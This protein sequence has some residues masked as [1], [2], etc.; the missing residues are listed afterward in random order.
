MTAIRGLSG[1]LAGL[2]LWTAGAPGLAAQAGDRHAL[3]TVLA[4]DQSP[5]SGLGPADFVVREDGAAR[6]VLSVTAAAPGTIVL[7]VDST[8]AARDVM[9][10]VRDGL[11]RFVDQVTAGPSRPAIRLATFADRPDTLADFGAGLPLLDKGIGLVVPRS[12]SGSRF[13]DALVETCRDLRATQRTGAA[14]VAFLAEGGPEFSDETRPRVEQA[15]KSVD[16][17]LWV[18]VLH[19]AAPADTSEAG[20]ERAMVV[21]DL[22][23]D[24][25]GQQRLVL[26]SSG[27]VPAF[28]SLAAALSARYDVTYARPDRLIPPSRLAVTLRRERGTVLVS[29][30]A[31]R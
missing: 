14:I 2:L 13:L 5:L 19:S 27:V 16:A 24:S 20:R 31:P 18:L 22:T 21:G 4:P 26:G 28:T 6:E 8:E 10:E 17:S 7:L 1:A 15:L 3:V 9:P 29:R 25:G 11:T 30:W 12:G 23:R